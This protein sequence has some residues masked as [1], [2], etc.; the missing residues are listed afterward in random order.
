MLSQKFIEEH[1]A[2]ITLT[3]FLLLPFALLFSFILKVRRFCF[4]IGIFKQYN[5]K[6]KIISVGNLVVGGTGKTPFTILLAKYLKSSKEST[7]GGKGNSVAVSHRGY[8]GKFENM[9][10]LISDENSAYDCAKDAGDEPFMLAKNLP[11]IPVIVGKNRTKAIK[12]LEKKFS[13]DYIILDDSFQHLKVKHNLDFLLFSAKNPIGNGFVMPAGML[14]EPKSVIK[15]CDFIVF[16]NCSEDFVIPEWIK[17]YEK[18]IFQTEYEIENFIN[19]QTDET[20]DISYFKNKK[21]YLISGIGNPESFENSIKRSGIDFLH[22]FIFPDHY[23]FR[24]ENDIRPIIRK[25]VKEKIDTI[26]TTEKDFM[27]MQNFP[28]YEINFYYAKLNIK[29]IP[30]YRKK[31]FE[32]LINK[33]LQH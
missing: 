1:W 16:N 3:S 23:H 11:G 2:R 27:K 6:C 9:V 33:H 29:I 31:E 21:I 4:T 13:P 26:L 18:P 17:K 8:K 32:E 28:L 5:S 15:F 24:Y 19:Y 30:M 7:S 10:K 20:E 22:H 25:G 12:Y 14:R